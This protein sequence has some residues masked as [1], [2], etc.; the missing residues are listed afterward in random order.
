MW[1]KKID[2]NDPFKYEVF[3]TLE[4]RILKDDG[5]YSTGFVLFRYYQNNSGEFELCKE[6]YQFIVTL[7]ALMSNFVVID[8]AIEKKLNDLESYK[9]KVEGEKLDTLLSP[10]TASVYGPESAEENVNATN[11][12]NITQTVPDGSN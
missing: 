3:P 12:D 1:V 7:E 9:R 2:R 5:T 8:S 6:E 4:R 11:S 10:F